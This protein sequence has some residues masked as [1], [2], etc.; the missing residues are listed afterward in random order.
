[1]KN[2]FYTYAY[3]REDGTPY[4]IGKGR[5]KR[6]YTKQGRNV[7]L[8][9]KDRILLLKTN[10]TEEEA[11]KHEI[12]MIA[13]YGRKDLGTGILYNFTDGGEGPSNPSDEIREA[14]R[15]RM[16]GNKLSQGKKRSEQ[17]KKRISEAL[18]GRTIL[19]ETRKKLSEALTGRTVSGETRKKLSEARKRGRFESFETKRKRA[20]HRMK[21]IEITFPSGRVGVFNSRASA[22]FYTSIST[23]MLSR[24]TKGETSLIEK[25]YSAR[26]L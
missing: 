18:T 16:L 23:S 26:Y 11:F 24:L 14:M 4:Y 19:G 10:L 12:Y 20:K 1:M 9:P 22:S 6:A 3:L 7:H 17:H 21:P 8:P 25:G 13:L 2:D 15:E 5:G